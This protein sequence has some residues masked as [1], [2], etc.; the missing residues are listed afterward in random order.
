[1]CNVIHVKGN[2]VGVVV[3]EV[4]GEDV[5]VVVVYTVVSCSSTQREIREVGCKERP[6]RYGKH[7]R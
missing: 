6:S 7:G 3:G 5:W 4:V 2:T 1:M